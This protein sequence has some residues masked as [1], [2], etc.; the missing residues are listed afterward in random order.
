MPPESSPFALGTVQ[1]GLSYGISNS[2]G[3][4]GRS[5]AAL[6]L[7]TCGELGVR[8]FDT[9]QAYGN[10]E[11][12]LG[13]LLTPDCGEIVTKLHP[14][15]D[16]RNHELVLQAVDQSRTRLQRDKLDLLMLHH[17][18]QLQ[19]WE[20]GLGTSL[21][22]C[23]QEGTVNALG[24]SVYSPVQAQVVCDN[25]HLSAVQVPASVF[26]RRVLREPVQQNLRNGGLRVFIRSV[27]LQ[28]LVFMDIEDAKIPNPM[29]KEA[30]HSYD[31]FCKQHDL[32]RRE[33]AIAYVR[34]R[35][36]E[37]TLVVGVA[38]AAQAAE[39]FGDPLRDTSN[40]EGV[41]DLWDSAYPE[42]H[43]AVYNPTQW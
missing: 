11:S 23:V 31:V 12:V 27:Y 37:A 14:E 39:T 15:T 38:S 33:F 6:I 5:E 30:L 34:T 36:P 25:A 13:E 21:R 10:S 29:A 20:Y 28:G 26:D 40:W 3:Q 42:D 19:D 4:P 2:L 7:K 32:C 17:Y 41:C 8:C 24:C 16:D 18:E 1:L 43:E 9:A 22:A 35:F